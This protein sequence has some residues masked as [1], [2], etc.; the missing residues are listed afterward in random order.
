MS[1]A[2]AR[3]VGGFELGYSVSATLAGPRLRT[4]REGA[5]VSLRKFAALNG[6]SPSYLSRVESGQRSA[7]PA[8]E[9]IY[10]ALEPAAGEPA[11]ISRSVSAPSAPR[12]ATAETA[13]SS[14]ATQASRRDARDTAEP[15]RHGAALPWFGAEVRRLRLEA[16]KSLRAL[17][18][19]V[20]LSHAQLGKIE[21]GDARGSLQLALALENALD[22]PGQLSALF[23]D[24]CARVGP[25]AP[26]TDILSGSGPRPPSGS[27]LDPAEH[28]ASAAARLAALRVLSHRSGPHTIVPGLRQG[29]I[30][31]Y[32]AAGNPGR[33]AAHPLW[34]VMLRY[35]E[36]L[37]WTAQETGLPHIGLRWTRTVADWAAA[38]GDADALAYA[39]VRQSQWARRRGNA[40]AA[41]ELARRA[42]AVPGISARVAGFAAQREAQAG[43]LAR[44]EPAFRRALER[45]QRLTADAAWDAGARERPL[46]AWGPTPDPDFDAT[47]L[48]EATCLIDLAEFRTA[49]A[50]FEQGMP[51]LVAGRTGYAR[52]ALR[53]AIAAAYVGE[54]EYACEVAAAALPTLTRQ[55]SASLRGDLKL[56]VRVL[57]R[58]RHS[59]LV[60]A[61]LPDLTA[62]LRGAG[63]AI[64]AAGTSSAIS[65]SARR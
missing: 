38:L 59:P 24:E 2:Y 36:L 61:L 27:L 63:G 3:G 47:G 54:P 22:A 53:Q 20:F 17:G 45:Y 35:A 18:G 25:V 37:G 57:N 1:P 56:L 52:L 8:L 26:D 33:E 31:L 13:L 34:P 50:R 42:A 39:L 28:A 55:G 23:L 32:D 44:D 43:A 5:G 11:G 9:R 51:R 7:T 10:A 48:F 4:R 46:A 62:A 49:A 14:P 29:V 16:G 60:R 19:E 64:S 6:Y 65:T 30:E 12:P 58:Y 15:G 21:Q 40:V 41:V